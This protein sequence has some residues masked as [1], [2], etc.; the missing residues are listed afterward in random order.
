MFLCI[1]SH[2]D[3]ILYAGDLKFETKEASRVVENCAFYSRF[4]GLE[5][6]FSRKVEKYVGLKCEN[7]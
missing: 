4:L 1:F 7:I 3:I 5:K 2:N 6:Y